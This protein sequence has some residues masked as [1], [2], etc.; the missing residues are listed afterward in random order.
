LLNT[1]IKLYRFWNFNNVKNILN[2][3]VPIH[4]IHTKFQ[5]SNNDYVL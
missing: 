1:L 4:Y 2:F 5:E 3:V